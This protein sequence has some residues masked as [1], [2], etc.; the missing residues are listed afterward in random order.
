MTDERI[1]R[2]SSI[3]LGW[4]LKIGKD[5]V[6]YIDGFESAL[7]LIGELEEKA[8]SR[9]ATVLRYVPSES[10]DFELLRNGTEDQISSCRII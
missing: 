5:D 10:A 2:M 8:R 9:G 1:S 4:S 3:I 6:L 7:P